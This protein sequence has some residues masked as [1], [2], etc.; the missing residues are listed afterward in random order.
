MKLTKNTII[1]SL[2]TFVQ[3]FL[4]YLVVNATMID[5]TLGYSAIKMT[6]IGLVVSAVS[7]GIAALMNLEWGGNADD[8]GLVG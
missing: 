1:R 8:N 3:A 5:Y 6:I 4:A 7:A 2:R